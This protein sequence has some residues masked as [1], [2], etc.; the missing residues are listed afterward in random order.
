MATSRDVRDIMQLGPAPSAASSSSLLQ[1]APSNRRGGGPPGPPAK[2]LDGITRE[3]YALMGDNQPALALAQPV[4]PKFKE[5]AKAV[6]RSAHWSRVGF[7]NP[8]RGA[9]A[10]MTAAAA[11]DAETQARRKLVLK[12]WVKDLGARHVDGAPDGKFAKFN[13]SSQPYSYTDAEYDAWLKAP[14]WSK[15]DTDQLFALAR[16]LD[17]RFIVMADRWES[18]P[19]RSVDDLKNRYYSVCRA[20]AQNRPGPTPTDLAEKEKV[21][22]A[23]QEMVSSFSFDLNRELERKAYL[24]SLLSRTPAQ[25]AEEDFLYIESRRIEQNYHNIASERAELLHLLGGREGIG[26][27]ASGGQAGAGGGLKGLSQSA[28]EAEKKKR[29]PGWEMVAGVNA[30]PEGWAGE[31]SKRRIT[32][33]EDAALCIERHPI[34]TGII[35]KTSQAPAASVRSSR[36]AP[37]KSGLAAKVAAALAETGISTTLIMP[38]KGNIGKL[39]DLQAALTQML[40]LKRAVDRVQ[41]EIRLQK[42]KR[43]HLL[44][45]EEP[46]IKGEEEDDAKGHANRNKR[47]ASVASSTVSTKRARRE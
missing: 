42:K 27:T 25:I 1:P 34:P 41:G 38:T 36:I 46:V 6:R 8:A 40:E 39:D 7:T 17:L 21:D 16:Q 22:K 23:R 33:A 15:E 14:D 44:G 26:K 13:T 12:H 28:K 24:R 43:S 2:R 45:E 11:A 18:S 5:R 19:N 20:L 35:P 10:G 47:S 30:L 9:E 32:A 37:V 4:K 31:G 29:G 3:L